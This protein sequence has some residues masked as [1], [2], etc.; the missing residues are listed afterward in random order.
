[1]IMKM[2]TL[3]KNNDNLSACAA[4]AVLI[5]IYNNILCTF[6]TV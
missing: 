4:S 6:Q 5:P 2:L 3:Y 1:M